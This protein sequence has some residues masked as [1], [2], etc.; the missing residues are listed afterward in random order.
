M[1]VLVIDRVLCVLRRHAP[2][3]VDPETIG[4]ETPL[5]GSASPFDSLQLI[6]AMLAL[7][8]ELGIRLREE[9]VTPG[10]FRSTTTLAA[11]LSA[12]AVRAKP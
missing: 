6:Q 8:S 4:P 1:P 7:E 9:D 3:G 12:L 11:V 10:T 2:P 5:T